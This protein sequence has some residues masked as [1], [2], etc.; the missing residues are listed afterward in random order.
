[1][2]RSCLALIGEWEE[3][4]AGLRNEAEKRRKIS[5][6]LS[7]VQSRD[8]ISAGEAEIAPNGTSMDDEVKR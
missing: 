2:D 5:E 3:K 6:A 1:M 8:S 7:R 4:K